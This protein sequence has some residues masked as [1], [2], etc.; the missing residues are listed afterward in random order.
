MSEAMIKLFSTFVK[1]KCT[2]TLHLIPNL[3]S[4]NLQKM[5]KESS[6]D[7]GLSC[8]NGIKA[9][10]MIFIITSHALVFMVGGPVQNSEFFE[11]V[12]N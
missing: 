5:V 9:I 11:R 8:L 6:D 12:C 2:L 1:K 10:A 7:L 3:F 4:E